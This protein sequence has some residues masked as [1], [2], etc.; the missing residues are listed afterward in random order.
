MK[1]IITLI[2]LMFSLSAYADKPILDVTVPSGNSGNSWA[3]GNLISDALRKSGYDSKIVH[4][5]KCIPNK[6][7]I[8]KNTG[9]PAIFVRSASRYVRDESRNCKIAITDKTFLT[10][11]YKRHQTMCVRSD[12]GFTNL[13]DFLSGKTRITVATTH[14]LPDNIFAPLTEQTGVKFVR[15]S[16]K[17]S[18][19]IIKGLVAGDTDLMYSGFTARELGTDS[20]NCFTTSSDKEVGGRLP[21]QLLFPKWQM[22]NIGSVKYFHAVNIPNN[23]L[24]KVKHD[25]TFITK[26]IKIK[27][28]LQKSYMTPGIEIA[29]GRKVFDQ[30]VA[31]ILANK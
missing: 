31:T 13:N 29:N 14:S 23:M 8:E 2:F 27:K 10:V 26:D 5:K 20:I 22:N 15:V 11:F 6:N 1:L 4:T 18:K 30:H 28:Y 19:N 16:Y 24:A 21:M 12:S 9:R 3:E 25:L 17:G 7:Y